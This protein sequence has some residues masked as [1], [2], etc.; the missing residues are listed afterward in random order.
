MAKTFKSAKSIRSF[1]KLGKKFREIDLPPS[2]RAEILLHASEPIEDEMVRI[3][4]VDTGWLRST[5]ERFW[6]EV[7]RIIGIGPDADY[8]EYVEFGT[9]R[10]RAQPY[11]RPA[12]DNNKAEARKRIKDGIKTFVR[13]VARG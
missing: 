1:R 3:V 9:S 2:V 11:V 4:P 6:I 10:Q 5:I 12:Y 8:D 7:D 13:E